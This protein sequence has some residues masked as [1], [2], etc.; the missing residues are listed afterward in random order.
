MAPS[1]Q[2]HLTLNVLFRI[3]FLQYS[4]LNPVIHPSVGSSRMP[5]TDPDDEFANLLGPNF[6]NVDPTLL[7]EGGGQDNQSL[8]LK[9]QGGFS[10]EYRMTPILATGE[11]NDVLV[12]V[13][14]TAISGCDVS[15]TNELDS[16]N[17]AIPDSQL[18]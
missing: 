14:F 2:S 17:L 11:P 13:N 7:E 12:K 18:S 1:D 8:V 15:S 6:E 10:L 9:S 4:R 5:F 3:L 16:L